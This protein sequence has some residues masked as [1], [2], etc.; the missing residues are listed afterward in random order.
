MSE[1]I[2]AIES[3]S[4][5]IESLFIS[6]AS[7]APMESLTQATLIAG[8][9]IEGDRYALQTG[10][11]SA[12]FFGEPGKNLTMMSADG[13]EAAMAATG[14]QPFES[15]GALRR[16]VVIRG[17]TAEALNSIIGHE[18]SVGTA[19]VRLFLHRMTVPCRYREAQTQ[20]AGLMNKLWDVCGVNCEILQGGTIRVGDVVA[21]VPNSHQ[22]K[23]CD[24]GTK[25]PAFFIKPSERTAEQAK[26]MVIPP[27]VATIMCLVDPVGFQRVEEGYSSV[28]AHFWSPKAY[29]AGMLAKKARAPLLA[30][31]GVALLAVSVG[32]ARKL[33]R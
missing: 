19:G 28:G 26:S 13:V 21:V 6:P 1:Q 20:R 3:L 31:L 22:P 17:V 27:F 29:K 16:N 5:T 30:T 14:M 25:P 7:A 23:R 15:L 2:M 12:K 8:V 24:P 4:A 32:V 11:Y 18:V 9:G 33:W 10:T